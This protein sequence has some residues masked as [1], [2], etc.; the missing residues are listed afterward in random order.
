MKEPKAKP[1]AKAAAKPTTFQPSLKGLT[2]SAQ[3]KAKG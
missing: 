2:G 3:P 1:K